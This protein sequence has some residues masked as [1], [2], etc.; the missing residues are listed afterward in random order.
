MDRFLLMVSRLGWQV[1][2]VLA[3]AVLV[4]TYP[5]HTTHQSV[6]GVNLDNRFSVWMSQLAIVGILAVILVVSWFAVRTVLRYVEQDRWPRK[7]GSVEIEELGRAETQLVQ[8]ADTL[9]RATDDARMLSRDL[10]RARETI[11]YLVGEL[12]RGKPLSRDEDDESERQ[13]E[14]E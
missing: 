14:S 12:E 7:A 13:A 11:A 1:W 8:D 5:H 9:S 10:T 3:V 6:V 4:L 2:T